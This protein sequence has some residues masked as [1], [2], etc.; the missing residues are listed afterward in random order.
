MGRIFH[1]TVKVRVSL[2]ARAKDYSPMKALAPNR[3]ST[4]EIVYML[5]LAELEGPNYKIP[6]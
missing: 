1:E 6:S 5:Q 2:Q 4:G 3:G